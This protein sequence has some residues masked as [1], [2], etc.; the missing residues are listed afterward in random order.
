[1]SS[2]APPGRR[3]A[4]PVCAWTGSHR[5]ELPA[6]CQPE[7][8]PGSPGMRPGSSMIHPQPSAFAA[9]TWNSHWRYCD[10]PTPFD[11]CLHIYDFLLPAPLWGLFRP[12]SSSSTNVSAKPCWAQTIHETSWCHLC[13]EDLADPQT[14]PFAHCFPK[15]GRAKG[16]RVKWQ[17]GR[18]TCQRKRDLPDFFSVLR[19]TSSQY[20]QPTCS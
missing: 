10:C 16:I 7:H 11:F 15:R 19:H 4:L 18:C 13:E 17:M 14:H 6:A 9:S 8:F 2:P 20:S 1:M 5:A 3:S 12:S